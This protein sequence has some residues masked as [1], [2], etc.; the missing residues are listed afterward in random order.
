MVQLGFNRLFLKMLS[1]TKLLGVR[2]FL[3]S[4]CLAGHV[5]TQ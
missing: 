1:S 2:L 5:Q 4:E 3:P